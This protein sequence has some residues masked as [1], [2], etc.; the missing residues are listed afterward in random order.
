MSTIQAV[1]LKNAA[2]ASN[3]IVLDASGNAT[4]AGTAAM[5]SSF[6]RNRIINGDMRIDQRNAGA[7]VTVPTVGAVYPVDRFLVDRANG[8]VNTATA[9][10]VTDAPT[11]FISS[12]RYTAGT[13]ET[14]TGGLFSTIA[15]RIEGFNIS[16][17]AWGSSGA[18]PARLSFWAKISITGTFG[19][20]LR[21][22]DATQTFAATFTYSSANT[23]QFVTISVPAPTTGGTTAFPVGNGVG[24]FVFWE[25]GT[26]PSLSINATGAW[27]AANALGVTGATKLNS[28]TGATYQITGV[29]L[30]VGT[31]ATPFERRLFGQ[32]LALCQ[33]YYQAG[34]FT[35]YGPGGQ[36]SGLTG[37]WLP[38]PVVMRAS[39]TIALISPSYTNASSL[40]AFNANTGGFSPAFTV[41][42]SNASVA[43]GYTSASEL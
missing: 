42:G 5:A 10:Q 3:N 18:S 40:N 36:T 8:Y 31:V 27:Q 7:S 37:Q 16:D 6:L 26:G 20:T 25:L 2:S 35:L 30:E 41:T 29:Q 21:S 32:E 22:G 24:V 12:L 23:W 43:S 38:W 34:N 28:T 1:N 11:G 4:F 9:Q 15:Q 17:F 13:A 19:V 14:P 33:R 39:P